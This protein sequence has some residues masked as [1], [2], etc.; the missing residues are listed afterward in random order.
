[1]T[2]PVYGIELGQELLAE[3]REPDAAVGI[4]DHVVRLD[5]F[6]RQIVFGD[7]HARGAAFRARRGRELEAVRRAAAEVERFEI[8][9]ESVA[10]AP[11]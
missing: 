9:G 10:P 7:D 8:A 6:S 4:D 3:M 1:M 5:L 2:L 11:D